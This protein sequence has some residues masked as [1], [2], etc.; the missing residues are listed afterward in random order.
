MQQ[1]HVNGQQV[2]NLPAI[3]DPQEA[4]EMLTNFGLIGNLTNLQRT[5]LVA[6]ADDMMSE[7]ARSIVQLAADTGI[8]KS[9]IHWNLANPKFNTALGLLTVSIVR[10][11]AHVY[12]RHMDAIATKGKGRIQYDALKF[13]LEYGGTYVQRSSVTSKSVHMNVDATSKPQQFG[14]FDQ[15]FDQF[16]IMCGQ[17]GISAE[18][19]VQRYR[20]LKTEQAW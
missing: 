13:M 6:L 7:K 14:E 3:T 15:S 9:A 4:D 2:Q 20:E 17:K 8:S 18:R 10:G 12:M 5:L 16:L 1:A 11:R 19:I